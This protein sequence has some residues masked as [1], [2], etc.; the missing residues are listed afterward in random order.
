MLLPAV[1]PGAAAAY[2]LLFLQLV[3]DL[4]VTLMLQ[5]IGVQ[6]LS[7]RVF[8]RYQDAFL[9]DAGLAGLALVTVALSGQLAT[10]RWRRHA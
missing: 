9:H 1:A 10:L 7:F 3:K 2:L 6:T 5:P 4:P 8:D